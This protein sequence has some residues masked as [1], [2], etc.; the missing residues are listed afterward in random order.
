M[1]IGSF[2]RVE[3]TSSEKKLLTEPPSNDTIAYHHYKG[4]SITSGETLVAK[5]DSLYNGSNGPATLFE[6]NDAK[7]PMSPQQYEI[8]SNLLVV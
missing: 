3:P 7:Y 6:N 5:Y 4:N 2:N 8:K 1:G